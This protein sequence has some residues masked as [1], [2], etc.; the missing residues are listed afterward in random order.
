MKI[1]KQLFQFLTLF[2]STVFNI[3]A[4][5]LPIMKGE[6]HKIRLKKNAVPY[7]A[8]TPIPVPYHWKE[9]VKS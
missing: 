3:E 6:P 2:S 4:D 1:I 9:E 7:A 5:I 8:H